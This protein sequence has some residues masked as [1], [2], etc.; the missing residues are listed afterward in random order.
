MSYVYPIGY[1]IMNRAMTTDRINSKRA[2]IS[3]PRFNSHCT[4]NENG[5]GIC[6]SVVWSASCVN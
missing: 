5:D 3:N 4:T 6:D 1:G 2:Q